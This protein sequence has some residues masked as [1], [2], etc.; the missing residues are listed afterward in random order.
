[1]DSSLAG[2]DPND[3]K[4][5]FSPKQRAIR[6]IPALSENGIFMIVVRQKRPVNIL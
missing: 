6:P 1:M 4:P 2:R 5:L 3:G